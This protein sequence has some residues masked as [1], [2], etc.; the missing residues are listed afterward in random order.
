[1]ADP[2]D[3]VDIPGIRGPAQPAGAVS[4][5]SGPVPKPWLGIWFRCCHTYGRLYKDASGRMYVGR[6]PKCGA[7]ASARVGNGGSNR[8]LF[9][10]S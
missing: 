9:E 3:I 7:K 10:A 1:V 2:R 8:R 5:A 4:A 6:C